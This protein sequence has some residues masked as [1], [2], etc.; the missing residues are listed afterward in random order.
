MASDRIQRQVERLLDVAEKA[1]EEHDWHAL[2][3]HA[4][5]V[6][7]LDPEN[8]EAL[9]FFSVAERGIR[10]LCAHS[11]ATTRTLTNSGPAHLL[12]QRPLRSKALPGRGRQ[13]A[14]LFGPGHSP[15][16]RG[17]LCSDQD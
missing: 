5:D 17:S 13:E 9:T 1:F 10:L 11:S 4:Q 6:I 16:Q 12:R 7:R 2:L 8:R 14:G 3:A 15:R